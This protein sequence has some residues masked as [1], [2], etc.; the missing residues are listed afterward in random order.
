M[1]V[2]KSYLAI[3]ID[4]TWPL[5]EVASGAGIVAVEFYKSKRTQ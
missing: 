4:I 1:L 3:S 2:V 5:P